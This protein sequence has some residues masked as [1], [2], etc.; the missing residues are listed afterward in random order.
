[1]KKNFISGVAFS[2]ALAA[3]VLAQPATVGVLDL[4]SV[5]PG[6]DTAAHAAST[7]S[8]WEIIHPGG[9][10]DVDTCNSTFDTELGIY[11]AAGDLIGNN[12]DFCGTQSGLD[13]GVLSAGSYYAAVS[14]YNTAFNASTF[15]VIAGTA[16]GDIVINAIA[17]PV[18]TPTTDGMFDLTVMDMDMATNN[19]DAGRVLWYEIAHPGG[20]LTLTTD[21][22]ETTLPDTE[23]GLYDDLGN[24]I[25]SNDDI[26][27]PNFLSELTVSVP[28]GTYYAATGGFNMSFGAAYGVTSTDLD[29]GDVKLA[30]IVPEPSSI[31]LVLSSMLGLGLLRRRS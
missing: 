9:T 30:A 12:D 18:V 16:A 29:L 15:D 17:S 10:L 21:F 24:F 27:F 31:V 3:L 4:T 22:A 8:W 20:D 5:N 19:A 6:T 28:A 14:G 26:G 2:V 25:D 23:V 7:V 11:D 13:A 1:M